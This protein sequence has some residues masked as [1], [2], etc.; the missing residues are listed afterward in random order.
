LNL[1]REAKLRNERE[2]NQP[3]KKIDKVDRGIEAVVIKHKMS[4][5]NR[6]ARS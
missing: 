2:R 5:V 1:R 6:K 4:N 3:G